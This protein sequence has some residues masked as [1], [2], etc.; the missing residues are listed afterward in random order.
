MQKRGTSR[1]WEVEVGSNCR[2]QGLVSQCELR[3][4]SMGN[5]WRVL[6]PDWQWVSQSPPMLMSLGNKYQQLLGT[7]CI[8]EHQ[9]RQ[10]RT[11]VMYYPPYLSI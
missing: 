10:Q 8:S 4:Y 7:A 3:L 5:R 9:Y 1:G 6:G 11:G 2:I